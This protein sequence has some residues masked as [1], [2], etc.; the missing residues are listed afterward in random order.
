MVILPCVKTGAVWKNGNV[1]LLEEDVSLEIKAV[2]NKM[3]AE[4]NK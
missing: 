2:K 3:K 1:V 4:F